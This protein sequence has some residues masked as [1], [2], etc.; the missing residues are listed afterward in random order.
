[1]TFHCAVNAR[2]R[3]FVA[4][5]PCTTDATGLET[6]QPFWT[7][8]GGNGIGRPPTIC[9]STRPSALTAHEM[10]AGYTTLDE[11]RTIKIV[12]P[13]QLGNGRLRLDTGALTSERRIPR[14]SS[15]AQRSKRTSTRHATLRYSATD[16][17]S[18]M[19]VGLRPQ[20]VS[21]HC[22]RDARVAFLRPARMAIVTVSTRSRGDG[23]GRGHSHNLHVH[24]GIA[25]VSRQHR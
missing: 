11:H 16:A 22:K 17:A 14:R 13:F 7:G 25:V 12:D 18:S 23:L 10:E 9:L 6:M 24:C 3:A 20:C 19:L 1:M 4:T 15:A 2:N 21:V 8:N 5:C